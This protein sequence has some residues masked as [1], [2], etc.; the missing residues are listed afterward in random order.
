MIKKCKEL[1]SVE[2][3]IVATFETVTKTGPLKGFWDDWQ[4][5]IS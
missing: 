4:S 2:M 5:S 1:M 3:N